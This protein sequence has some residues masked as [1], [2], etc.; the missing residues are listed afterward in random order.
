WRPRLGGLQVDATGD[1][2]DPLVRLDLDDRPRLVG[3]LRQPDVFGAV[4]GK[5][6]DAAVIGRCTVLVTE[7]E[8]FETEH[9]DARSGRRPVGRPRPE[10]AEA[11]DDDVELPAAVGHVEE[12][13]SRATRRMAATL[14][15]SVIAPSRT[16]ATASSNG[17]QR[18]AIDSVGSGAGFSR[19]RAR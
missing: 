2:H 1:G 17:T 13:R 8:A 14:I 3:A 5:P 9:A 16:M 18:I 15:A 11:H 6:D 7:L 10:G 12:R 4:V 19:Q